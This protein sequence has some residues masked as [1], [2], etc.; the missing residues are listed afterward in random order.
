MWLRSLLCKHTIPGLVPQC[1]IFI[2]YYYS[3][4]VINSSQ[5]NFYNSMVNS[6]TYVTKVTAMVQ[7]N[8]TKNENDIRLCEGDFKTLSSDISTTAKSL[9]QLATYKIGRP[10][11][12]HIKSRGGR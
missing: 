4:R 5:V 3:S 8:L 7:D 2:V 12:N 6:I 1:R 11:A 10:T 9:S